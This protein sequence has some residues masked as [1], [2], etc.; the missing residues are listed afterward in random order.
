MDQEKRRQRE[1]KRIIKRQGNKKRRQ[2][3]KKS[4][5]V[6]PDEA[7]LEDDLFDF[8]WESSEPLNDLD[9]RHKKDDDGKI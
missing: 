1:L 3:L 6:N 2:Q 8:G 4:L 5:R 9:R 7:H